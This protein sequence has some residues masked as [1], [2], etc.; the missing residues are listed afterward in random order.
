MNENF[1]KLNLYLDRSMALTT[2]LAVLEWDDKTAAPKEA[3]E[4]TSKAIAILSD[5]YFQCLT[6]NDLKK[7]LKQL[8]EDE[9]LTALENSIFMELNKIYKKFKS[10]PTNEYKAYSQLISKATHI[11]EQARE[12]NNFEDFAPYLKEIVDYKRKFAG[13]RAKKNIYNELLDD[14]E[15][16]FTMKILDN[17]FK[18]LKKEIVP[19]LNKVVAKNDIINK[20]Y[21]KSKYDTKKQ[22]EFSR[23]IAEYVGFDFNKGIIAESTHPFTIS[24]HNHDVRITTNYIENNL[25]SSIFSTLH[26]TGHAIY[27]MGIDDDFTQTLVGDA[28]M[29][30]HESQ[31][32]F[33]ENI[34]GRSE[35]FWKPI[36][37]KL[38]N[39]FS[40]QL[41][42]VSLN[43]FIKGI[44]KV[45]SGAIRTEADE[46]TYCLHIM[47]RYEIEKMLFSN[48]IEI[49]DLPRVWNEKYEEYLGVKPNNNSEGV[50]Q[51][52]HWAGGDF[53]YFP[54]YAIGSA[55]A[56]QIFYHM[57]G[58]MPFDKYLLEG[59][60]TSIR[61]YLKENIHKYGKT[62]TTNAILSDMMGEP[63]NPDYYI[64]Y[65]KEKYT[66]IYE[67]D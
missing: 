31:S 65:L 56:A 23:W 62:K 47:I 29:G 33:F 43:E 55:I 35:E 57:K 7:I 11:W 46:L 37:P 59:N 5:Q 39:L 64:K 54:S 34:I 24:L 19:L 2:A 6:N 61:E 44:N 52:I 28:T 14:Y 53:G 17:F 22:A 32:R 9:S 1:E 66:K 48:K 41:K 51:D 67:L 13:Y 63:F 21:N 45:E 49:K 4:N 40:K 3:I 16:G 12:N 60:L 58:I 50:L 38:Q 36:Y 25:E 20:K 18:K 27:E 10:I 26:E 42:S 15:E 8:D 30:M